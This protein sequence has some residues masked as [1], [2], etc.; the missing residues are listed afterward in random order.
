[1]ADVLGPVGGIGAGLALARVNL[2]TD[3]AMAWVVAVVLLIFSFEV[4][5]APPDPSTAGAVAST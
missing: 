5:G 2:H 4:S 1:M 3:S